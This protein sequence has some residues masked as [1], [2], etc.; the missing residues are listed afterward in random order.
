MG[1]GDPGLVPVIRQNL[2]SDERPTG[3]L[4]GDESLYLYEDFKRRKRRD[5]ANERAPW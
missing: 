1:P 4:P 3:I 2:R 5:L